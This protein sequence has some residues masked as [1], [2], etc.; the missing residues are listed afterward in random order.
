MPMVDDDP[1]TT[2]PE[3]YRTVFENDHVRVLDYVDEPGESTTPHRHPNSVMITLT[4]FHRR[5]STAVGDRDVELTANQ[6]LWL[7]A[8]RH[9]G[10]NTGTTPTHT[11]LIELKGA[12]AGTLDESVI[13]PATT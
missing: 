5:L 11:I 12:A 1:V 2:N 13:G 10:E 6:V 9:S 7:P 4:D 8:Q 3:H